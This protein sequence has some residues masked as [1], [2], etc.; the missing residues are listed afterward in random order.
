VPFHRSMEAVIE[1]YH[2]NAGPLL[3]ATTVYWYQAAG[4]AGTYRPLPVQ[5]RLN[6]FVAVEQDTDIHE[7][8]QLDVVKKN[9]GVVVFDAWRQVFSAD[10]AIVWKDAAK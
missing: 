10:H 4:V 8:E 5:Q 6:Y 3:Y 2:P 1:K 7:A 9:S